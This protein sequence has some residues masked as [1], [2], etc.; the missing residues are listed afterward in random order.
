MENLNHQFFDTYAQLDKLCA[1]MYGSA[2]GV[3]HYI[4][5][6]KAASARKRPQIRNWDFD[7][8]QLIRLRHI[9][10][11]LAHTPGAFAQPHCTQKD[12]DWM[13]QFHQRILTQTDPLASTRW[14]AKPVPTAH[15]AQKVKPAP[16]QKGKQ[17]PVV[18]MLF[19]VC[20]LT[21]LFLIFSILTVFLL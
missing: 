21:I 20:G 1:D 18:L 14:Q 10:N 11:T 16:P 13:Q 9:R 8:S 5:D 6:M 4:E 19:I 2:P 15:K 17:E 12:I 7:L 3:T